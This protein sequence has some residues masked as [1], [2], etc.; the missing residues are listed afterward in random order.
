MRILLVDDEPD[1]RTLLRVTFEEAEILVEEAASAREAEEAVARAVPDAIV[2]DLRM[3]V[4]DGAELCRRLRASPRTRELPVVIL[5]GE[6]GESL[7]RARAAG[8]DAVVRKPFSPLELLAVVERATGA[9][10]RTPTRPRSPESQAGGE[11]LVYA[12]DLSY[13]LGVERKQR[14]QLEESYEATVRALANALELKDTGTHM[15]SNRVQRYAATLLDDIAPGMADDDRGIAFGFLL[16]DVGK[17]GIPDE[18]LL[19]P[20]QLDP[21][22]RE[23]MQRHTTI[24]ERM[25]CGIPFLDGEGLRIVRSHHERWDGGGYPD[26]LAREEI[27]LGAR[28]FAVADALDA[29]TSDRPYRRALDWAVARE[30]LR[31]HA[32]SQFDPD[33]VDAFFGTERRLKDAR[34][35][36][37][38]A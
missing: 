35:E 17:I 19:K 4:V 38:A 15:H 23:L 12:R 26:G 25:L 7:E 24:G 18:I 32:G 31:T 10:V 2:L 3:P 30:E 8:A 28:V 27:S 9:T 22:E 21:V 33:V 29:M 14:A 13:L 34:R 37:T 11:L 20:G 5:T 6:S 36:L 16:H 1:L